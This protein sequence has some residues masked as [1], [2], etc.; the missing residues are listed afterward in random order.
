MSPAE[1][2][3]M[4]AARRNFSHRLFDRDTQ[5]VETVLDWLLA[6]RADGRL[7]TGAPVTLVLHD[8]LPTA[9]ALGPAVALNNGAAVAGAVH[10]CNESLTRAAIALGA[11]DLN[12]AAAHQAA[13]D[14]HQLGA[15]TSVTFNPNT[16]AVQV[17][18]GCL[19]LAAPVEM[20]LSAH[21]ATAWQNG[22]LTALPLSLNDFH[23][24][25]TRDDGI[26]RLFFEGGAPRSLLRMYYRNAIYLF[27]KFQVGVRNA[28]GYRITPKDRVVRVTRTSDA[29]TVAVT[30]ICPGAADEAAAAAAVIRILTDANSRLAQDGVATHITCMDCPSLQGPNNECATAPLSLRHR[31]IEAA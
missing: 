21:L 5:F 13:L 7:A 8:F 24:G 18:L 4:S 1:I 27:L 10:L 30:A 28:N 3:A 6:E 15:Q 29:E 17:R 22:G 11:T 9:T 20:M 16:G 2:A 26:G 23:A 19:Q 31:H 14:Q 25:M 12:T